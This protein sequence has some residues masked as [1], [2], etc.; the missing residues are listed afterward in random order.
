MSELARQASAALADAHVTASESLAS[1]VAIAH[2]ALSSSEHVDGL[3]LEPMCSTHG[4]KVVAAVLC[5]LAVAVALLSARRTLRST[6]AAVLVLSALAG[7]CRQL[8]RHFSDATWEP[9][10][11]AMV[12]PLASCAFALHV[13]FVLAAATDAVATH[14]ETAL[15]KVEIPRIPAVVAL[16]ILALLAEPVLP[17]P[18]ELLTAVGVQA[19]AAGDG[20][21]RPMGER[22]AAAALWAAVVGVAMLGLIAAMAAFSAALR[23][24]GAA[25]SAAVAVGWSSTLALAGLSIAATHLQALLDP[26]EAAASGLQ[27]LPLGLGVCYWP[28]AQVD[29]LAPGAL[30]AWFKESGLPSIV[31]APASWLWPLAVA[32]AVAALRHRVARPA[33]SVGSS[34][35]SRGAGWTPSVAQQLASQYGDAARVHTEAARLPSASA[36]AAA[37]GAP[38]PA[39]NGRAGARPAASPYHA[40]TTGANAAAAQQQAASAAAQQ[41]AAAAA[42]AAANV[43]HELPAVA[44]AAAAPGSRILVEATRGPRKR[45]SSFSAAAAF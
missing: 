6:F 27:S 8:P 19:S 30:A 9:L 17:L 2:E 42:A 33:K 45:R 4:G 10:V 21:L 14:F 26:Q 37:V 29:I 7:V 40:S 41:A 16:A 44:Q 39:A 25:L 13:S 5:C 3:P 12:F 34:G 15:S 23:R 38:S 31:E 35:S 28:L 20:A 22:A 11:H 24:V 32:A 43:W 36:A 1:A 18:S